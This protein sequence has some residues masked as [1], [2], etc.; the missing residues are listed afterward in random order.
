MRTVCHIHLDCCPFLYGLRSSSF[1]L[2]PFEK[3]HKS[4]YNSW[5]GGSIN[6]R[7]F[8]FRSTRYQ[9]HCGSPCR[10]LI[11]IFFFSFPYDCDWDMVLYVCVYF[12]S[13]V[14]I[15]YR[16]LYLDVHHNVSSDNRRKKQWFIDVLRR[17]F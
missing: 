17:G 2:P 16:K 7:H 6:Q 12:Y 11:E 3:R 1:L 5:S 4:I 9:F 13:F 10:R 14:F 15:Y 8:P